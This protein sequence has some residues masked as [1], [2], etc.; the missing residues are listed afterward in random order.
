[1]TSNNKKH[2]DENITVISITN[3]MT[4]QWSPPPSV[5]QISPLN[6]STSLS[7]VLM[8]KTQLQYFDICM[9]MDS[10]DWRKFR[11]SLELYILHSNP[12]APLP[13]LAFGKTIWLQTA[14]IRFK[15]TYLNSN[16]NI[17]S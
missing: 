3:H 9:K 8:Y 1:M 11:S 17:L 10:V 12:Q 15:Y 5:S 2:R 4:T 14:N 16:K 13:T 6:L 7:G